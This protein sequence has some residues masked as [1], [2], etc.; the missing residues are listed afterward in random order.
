MNTFNFF[1]FSLL[2]IIMALCIF[3]YIRKRYINGIK[4]YKYKLNNKK[5]FR[6]IIFFSGKKVVFKKTLSSREKINDIV[7]LKRL[8]EIMQ[9]LGFNI[10]ETII[11]PKPENGESVKVDYK[12]IHLALVIYLKATKRVWYKKIINMLPKK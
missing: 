8:L 1:I 12:N 2:A 11:L 10:I 7:F 5:F 9:I 4:I 3:V 6:R